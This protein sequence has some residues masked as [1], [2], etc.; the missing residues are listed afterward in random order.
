MRTLYLP[1]SLE[2]QYYRLEGQ[3]G[4]GYAFLDRGDVLRVLGETKPDRFVDEIGQRSIRLGG[5]QPQCPVKDGI[6]VDSR[7]FL[8]RTHMR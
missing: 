6:E 7:S 3:I 1:T 4:F 8:S 5:F 2:F